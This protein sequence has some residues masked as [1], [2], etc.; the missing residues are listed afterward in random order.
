MDDLLA[1]IV[2]AGLAGSLF[3]T[4]S[5]L[6]IG[7]ATLLFKDFYHPAVGARMGRRPCGS[8]AA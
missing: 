7:A 1:A 8:S 3:G 2:V 4:I 5:A 6:S